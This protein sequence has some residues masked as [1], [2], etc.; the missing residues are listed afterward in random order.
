MAEVYT[1]MSSDFGSWANDNHGLCCAS[2]TRRKAAYPSRTPAVQNHWGPASG[3]HLWLPCRCTG[4]QLPGHCFCGSLCGI[5]FP[6]VSAGL[7]VHRSLAPGSLSWSLSWGWL[8]SPEFALHRHSSYFPL[9]SFHSS[10][11]VYTECQCMEGAHLLS[12]D[13]THERTTGN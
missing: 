10:A 7:N 4:F 3:D 2:A 12:D 1:K 13:W 5:F 11:T 8:L 9:E 6:W